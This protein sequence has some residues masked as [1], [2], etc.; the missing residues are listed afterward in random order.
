MTQFPP[1]DFRAAAQL[2]SLSIEMAL[3]ERSQST[4]YQVGPALAP[5]MLCDW[6]LWLWN[7][8]RTAVFYNF[9]LDSFHQEF[10]ERFGGGKIPADEAG[11][12]QWWVSLYPELPPRLTNECIWLGMENGLFG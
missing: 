1:S 5:Y 11:F 10:I 2:K 12:T 7:E 3:V 8:G 6:Q 4:F 9:K